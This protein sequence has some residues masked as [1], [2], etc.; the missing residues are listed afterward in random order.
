LQQT[1]TLVVI[2]RIGR[3]LLHTLLGLAI[4]AFVWPFVGKK[5]KL[6]VTRWWCKLLLHCFNIQVVTHGTPPMNVRNTMFMANHV[7][8]AD[9]HALNSVIP[10]RFIAKLEIK[11][12]PIFG[13]LVKK[14]D[15]IFIDRTTRKDAARI[16]K[17][18]SEALESGDNIGFFPEGAT[19]DGTHL[20]N[21]KSSIL[22]AAISANATILPVAIRYSKPN[23]SVNLAMAYA[24][25]TTLVESMMSVLKQKNPV[26]EL[27]FLSPISTPQAN[28]QSASNAVFT[29]IASALNLTR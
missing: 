24:G 29:A 28:R 20:L 6:G 8:W 23:G 4:A 2:Y 10:L 12:W 27:R 7:S 13:Y 11:S 25:D 14:S 19:T 26:V 15:T 5:A 3:I 17:V 9:I 16:V 21:F 1:H 22:Q 18:T